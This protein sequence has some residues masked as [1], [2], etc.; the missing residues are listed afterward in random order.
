MPVRC[1]YTDLDGTLLGRGASLFTD[2]EGRFSLSQARALQAVDRAGA[3]VVLMSGR[4]RA[5]VHEDARLIG[6]PSYIFEAGSGV[7][8]DGEI[9]LLLGDFDA[10]PTTTVVEQVSARGVPELLFERYE[11]R[12]EFHEPWHLDRETSHLF[13][14]QVDADEVNGFLAESGHGDLR[15]LDNGAIGRR[16]PGI[17]TS[18]AYHLVPKAVSKAAAVEAHARMMGYDREQTV[19]VG[20]SL[21]DLDVARVVGRFFMVANGPERD[22]GIREALPRFDNVTVTEGQAGDGFFQAVVESLVKDGA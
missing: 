8:V 22:A 16:M 20:D 11:G 1:F 9:T 5:Q 3:E 17:E 7:V 19:A 14:G 6:Q 10:D 18:H 15:L 13:R 2:Y 4:R 21:E 12:L